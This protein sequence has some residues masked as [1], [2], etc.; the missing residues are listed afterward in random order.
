MCAAA[1][2]LAVVAG[3]G[4]D[5]TP[6]RPS[7]ATGEQPQPTPPASSAPALRAAVVG[8]PFDLAYWRITVA[9]LEC[10]TA[11]QLLAE[12]ADN[13]QA[14]TDRVCVATIRYTN[15]DTAPHAYGGVFGTV[16]GS[17]PTDPV[18]GFDDQGRTYDGRGWAGTPTNPGVSGTTQLIFTVA[19]TVTLHAVQIGTVKVTN[20]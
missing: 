5:K 7:P 8:K 18:V 3:C 16:A 9:S 19:A 6:A 17:E 1:L 10:G 14:P 4:A 12:N 20:V 15:I 2:V 11:A 13:G